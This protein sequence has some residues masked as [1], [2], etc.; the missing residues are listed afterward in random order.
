[1][2]QRIVVVTT[3]LSPAHIEMWPGLFFPAEA[4]SEDKDFVKSKL[5]EEVEY[6]DT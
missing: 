5:L 1:M 2:R 4:L 6:E 3:M